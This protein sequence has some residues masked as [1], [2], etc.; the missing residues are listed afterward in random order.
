MLIEREYEYKPKWWI[1]LLCGAMFGFATAFFVREALS[2][3]Q[4]LLINGIIE[5]SEYGATI[6]YWVFAFFSFCF[7]LAMIAA[8][9]HRIMYHQRIAFTQTEIIVPASRWSAA[10]KGIQ[11]ADISSL[12]VSKINGQK[13]LGIN[14]SGGKTVINTSMLPLK[15]FEEVVDFLTVKVE[16]QNL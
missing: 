12:S 5:L 4:G 7:V 3:K 14:Y 6:F 1:I 10:E 11:Y 13:F 2:N 8:I 9:Y 16:K 15:S